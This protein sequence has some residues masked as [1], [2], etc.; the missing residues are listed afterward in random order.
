MD[1]KLRSQM[2]AML[3]RKMVPLWVPKKDLANPLWYKKNDVAVLKTVWPEG[4]VI[5]PGA[6][7]VPELVFELYKL[8][9]THV[10]GGLPAD[11]R[12]YYDGLACVR[13]HNAKVCTVGPSY[14]FASYHTAAHV[15]HLLKHKRDEFE[16]IVR[17]TDNV[18]ITMEPGRAHDPSM[19][20]AWFAGAQSVIRERLATGSITLYAGTHGSVFNQLD[21]VPNPNELVATNVY[22]SLVPMGF[23]DRR[24]VTILVEPLG[25]VVDLGACRRAK[26]AANEEERR[27]WHAAIEER[28]KREADERRL[29]EAERRA[30]REERKPMP[31]APPPSRRTA[32]K[33]QKKKQRKRDDNKLEKPASIA[34]AAEHERAL[35]RRE[36]ERVQALVHR[37]ALVRLG[38]AIGRGE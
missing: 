29:A 13:I 12:L 15:A 38:D 26:E 25:V 17:T 22:I 8:Q 2:R 34:A 23:Y 11:A 7:E 6:G 14:Q 32:T 4:R 9:T 16:Q 21:A 19:L 5:L 36:A 1:N 27:R 28:Q 35:E 37:V 10:I 18:R 30:V 20:D 24:V 31:P 33:K 3:A